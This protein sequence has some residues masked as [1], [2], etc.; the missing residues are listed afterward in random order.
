VQVGK[1]VQD[2]RHAAINMGYMAAAIHYDHTGDEAAVVRAGE[3]EYG[4]WIAGA[5]VPEATPR[6]V[7]KLRRSPLSGD[8]R[9]VEGN[10]EL[11]AALAVN[12][13]AFPVYAM[14]GEERLALTAAGTV[15][16]DEDFFE[17][18][19]PMEEEIIEFAVLEDAELDDEYEDDDKEN[20]QQW[21]ADLVADEEIYAQHE[22]AGKLAALRAAAM[23][24]ASA[25]PAVVPPQPVAAAPG[26]PAPAVQPAAVQP[27]AAVEQAAGQPPTAEQGQLARQMNAS[28]S[29][30]QEADGSAPSQTAAPASNAPVSQQAAAPAPAAPAPAQ[31]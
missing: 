8:W 2:T 11:T 28:F 5:V 23:A 17:E 18:D 15:Y 10:L 13:P 19:E 22:R 30:I 24:P 25:D 9:R 27:G 14:E 29:I 21:L 16:P 4:V 20:R 26:Q 6:K 31:E 3:D 1:I 12:V 7:A